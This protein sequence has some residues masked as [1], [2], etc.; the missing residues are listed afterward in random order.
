LT[1]AS[2]SGGKTL[3]PFTCWSVAGDVNVSDG[4]LAIGEGVTITFAQAA[5]LRVTGQGRLEAVGSAA[6]PIVLRGQDDRRGAW[7][8]VSIATD[9]TANRLEHVHLTGA[10]NDAWTGNNDTK[11]AL[12]VDDTGG[13][14]LVSTRISRSGWYGL[15]TE[16]ASARLSSFSGVRFDDNERIARLHADTAGAFGGDT[17]FEGNGESVVRLAYGGSDQVRTAATWRRLS[18]PWLVTARVTLYAPV[19][20]EPGA[21]LRFAQGAGLHVR[22]DGGNAGSLD[23]TGTADA[24]IVFTGEEEL[25]GS[26]LGLGFETSSTSNKL[27]HASVRFAGRQGWNGNSFSKAALYVNSNATLAL[28]TV[29]IGMSGGYGLHLVNASTSKATCSGVTFEASNVSGPVSV[30]NMAAAACP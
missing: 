15:F 30:A 2:V 9:A 25:A 14:T 19:T 18:V 16:G 10:G 13:V 21:T 7:K 11:A 27:A 23:A 28:D 3:A 12:F 6:D 8:G 17:T 4:T 26:W 1:N 29:T 5:G 20:I 24:P 22:N